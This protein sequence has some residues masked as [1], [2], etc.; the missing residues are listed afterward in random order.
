MTPHGT[1]R[2]ISN[3]MFVENVLLTSVLFYNDEIEH[4][5]AKFRVLASREKSGRMDRWT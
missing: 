2:Y 4:V 1:Q 3:S 5:G